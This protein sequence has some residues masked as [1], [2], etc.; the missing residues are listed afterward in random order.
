LFWP[1]KLD[2]DSSPSTAD[3]LLPIEEIEVAAV[4][5]YRGGDLD[6]EV[7]SRATLPACGFLELFISV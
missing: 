3:F 2:R 7:K 6:G 5:T 1:K 4:D